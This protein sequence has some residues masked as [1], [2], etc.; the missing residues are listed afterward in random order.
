MRHNA[1]VTPAGA[2][3]HHKLDSLRRWGLAGLAVLL[4]GAARPALAAEMT[5]AIAPRW[6]GV[7]LTVP[8]APLRNNAGQTLQVTRLA[9]LFSNVSLWR[10]DGS[11]MR[12]DGQYGFIDAA[13]GRLTWTLRGVPDGD[14]TGLEFQVGVAP[15]ANHSDPGAWPAGH[16]LNPLV[17]ALHWGW[18]GGYVFL[19]LEGHWRE[20]TIANAAPAG[21][22]ALRGFSHHLATDERI[23]RVGFRADF[24][25]AGATTVKLALDLARVLA[26]QRFATDDGSESTHSASGDALA[27]RLAAAVERAWFWLGVQNTVRPTSD[28]DDASRAR[29]TTAGDAGTPFAFVVPAGFP[30]PALPAD[31]PLTVEGVRLGAALF[32]DSRL[33]GNGTQSCASCHAPERAFSDEVALSRG[34]NGDVG[35]RNAMPLM[36]LAWNSSFAWD[37]GQ[38]RVRDQTLA[39]WTNP[40]EM[41]GVPARAVKALAVDAKLSAQFAAAF[42]S[43]EITPERVTR[44][45]EQF[46]LT[47]VS[48]DAKFDVALRGDTTFTSD[49]LRG[50]ELFMTVSPAR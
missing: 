4:A 32:F 17:N 50:F 40:I 6:Q 49:E 24:R 15:G 27:P 9:A 26:P 20:A 13:S 28:S 21:P 23:M 2:A 48:A 8:S 22:E 34:A 37:G 18:Q 1:N 46:L 39:A 36:N 5:L 43:K 25:V 42:G 41:N 7:D 16:A 35:Q 33:S 19:A 10:A 38:A 45:L 29:N 31:N 47:Q 12:L 14:F 30:Q 44:A 11:V 3:R